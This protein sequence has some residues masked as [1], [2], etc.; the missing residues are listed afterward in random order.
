MHGRAD[1]VI[2]QEN[3]EAIIAQIGS[4]QKELAWWDDT[5][6]QMLVEGP[7]RLEVYARIAAFVE[8]I[9]N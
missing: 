7:R 9:E 4:L 5:G 3:A 1:T 2:R 6:H 8:G